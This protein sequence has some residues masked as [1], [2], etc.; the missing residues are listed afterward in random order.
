MANKY[1]TVCIV[2]PDVGDET[3]KGI[4]QRATATIEAGGGKLGKL[5]E[6]GRRKLAYA[7][8]KKAEGYY[9]VL[10]Y[11][12]APEVSKEIG[13]ILGLN[14]DVLRHQTI[15]IEIKKVKKVRRKKKADRAAAAAQGGQS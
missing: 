4:I 14:E 1:E 5:D 10:E 7:I 12:S 2:K 13:R 11:E 3:V 6:W 9:F 8:E 15:K